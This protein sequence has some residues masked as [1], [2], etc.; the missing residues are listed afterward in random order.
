LSAARP[1]AGWTVCLAWAGLVGFGAAPVW[2]R[3]AA[4][5]PGLGDPGIA[6]A[7][8]YVTEPAQ[9]V[10]PAGSAEP[11]S[12]ISFGR[13]LDI[14]G[15][16]LRLARSPGRFGS[17][18]GQVSPYQGPFVMPS[19][20][21]LRS[22]SISSRY[23]MR[24]HP[25]LGGSRFHAGLDLAA[26]TG[27]AVLATA[28]GKVMAAGWCGGYGYCVTIDHGRGYSTLFGHLSAIAVMPGD[29]LSAGQAVGNV[30]S[31]GRSTGPHLHYEIRRDGR[32]INPQT[33]L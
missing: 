22:A 26:P 5:A 28:P 17:G 20:S 19:G 25:V 31:T 3:N 9:R 1:L 23:G 4:P 6:L 33:H 27:A 12:G 14:E 2:A 21:P 8:A 15:T 30:G 18:G 16:P 10:V 13:A 7:A 32:P 11:A 29:V 24:W